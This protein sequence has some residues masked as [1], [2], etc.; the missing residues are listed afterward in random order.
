MSSAAC[1]AYDDTGLSQ[2]SSRFIVCTCPLL[3][4]SV[5]IRPYPRFAPRGTLHCASRLPCSTRHPVMS[6]FL[7]SRA[8]LQ[9]FFDLFEMLAAALPET[10]AAQ[11]EKHKYDPV[12]AGH[13]GDFTTGAETQRI[14][15]I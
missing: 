1:A 14:L 6:L 11:S 2:H 15:F 9:I 10:F 12:A 4:V 8:F 3:S 5:R 13:D 7:G